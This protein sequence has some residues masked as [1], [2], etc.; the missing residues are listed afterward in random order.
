M[1]SYMTC[2]LSIALEKMSL[3][4]VLEI[5]ILIFYAS[6]RG[7]DEPAHIHSLVRAFADRLQ[8]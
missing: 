6:S 8:C 3:E 5:M 2:I 4:P 7:Q 1:L